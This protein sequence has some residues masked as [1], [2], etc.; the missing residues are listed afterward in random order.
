MIHY[1]QKVFR[2]SSGNGHLNIHQRLNRRR[3]YLSISSEGQ[4]MFPTGVYRYASNKNVGEVRVGARRG[5]VV[6]VA[7]TEATIRAFTTSKQLHKI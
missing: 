3:I 4:R 2:A 5:H 7:E 1:Y 6:A